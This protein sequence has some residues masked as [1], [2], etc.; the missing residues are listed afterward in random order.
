MQ[1]DDKGHPSMT[2]AQVPENTK[3]VLLQPLIGFIGE[4]K[5]G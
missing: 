2:W 4:R 3:Q 5:G 1:P